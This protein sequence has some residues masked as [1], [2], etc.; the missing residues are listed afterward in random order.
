VKP[1]LE[2]PIDFVKDF[3]SEIRRRR[4]FSIER[5]RATDGLSCFVPQAAFYLMIRVH[6][7]QGANDEELVLDL[8]QKTGVL[9]VHGSGFGSDRRAGYFRMVYLADEQ[10][11]DAALTGIRQYLNG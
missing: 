11:L 10:T 2:G 6:K 7:G 3:I 9:V 1:A 4:D 5:V 8:L